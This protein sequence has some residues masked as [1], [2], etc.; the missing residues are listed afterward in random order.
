MDN[1]DDPHYHDMRL[2]TDNDI[3]YEFVAK[4]RRLSV[5]HI[6]DPG[7]KTN[8]IQSHILTLDQ[9]E[10][11]TDYVI[12]QSS[13]RGLWRYIIGDVITFVDNPIADVPTIRH[14]GRL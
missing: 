4:E 6:S 12:I 8:H 10:K 9:V 13:S 2:I 5:S 1:L 11:D 3:S 7:E 14:Q